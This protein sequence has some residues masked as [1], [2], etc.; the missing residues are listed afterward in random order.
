VG[1]APLSLPGTEVHYKASTSTSGAQRLSDPLLLYPLFSGP[2]GTCSLRL[3]SWP[4][5]VLRL[6]SPLSSLNHLHLAQSVISLSNRYALFFFL[7]F[8]LPP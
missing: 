7:L 6:G 3:D 2:G 5:Q 4:F 1:E 8:R